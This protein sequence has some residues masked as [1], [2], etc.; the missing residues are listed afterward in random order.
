MVLSFE[1]QKAQNFTRHTLTGHLLI[2]Q[3]SILVV[4]RDHQSHLLV[5]TVFHF[6]RVNFQQRQ[7][8]PPGTQKLFTQAYLVFCLH[9]AFQ[10]DRFVSLTPIFWIQVDSC[11]FCLS[12][13]FVQSSS[14]ASV[15]VCS[16]SCQLSMTKTTTISLVCSYSSV[17]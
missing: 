3:F 8:L 11:R 6:V 15:W 17:Q 16:T 10:R 1:V 5:L 9:L 14:K 2:A 13:D 12:R 7:V 4:N